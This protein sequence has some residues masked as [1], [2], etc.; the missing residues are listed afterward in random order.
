MKINKEDIKEIAQ[1]LYEKD[2]DFANRNLDKRF[3]TGRMTFE[4]NGQS[5]SMLKTVACHGG[6]SLHNEEQTRSFVMDFTKH[7]FMCRD[8]PFNINFVLLRWVARFSTTEER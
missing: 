1:I 7:E 8:F 3:I 4:E 2:E 5:P 6:F